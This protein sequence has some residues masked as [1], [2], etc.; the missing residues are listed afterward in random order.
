MDTDQE[1]DEPSRKLLSKA[2]LMIA[3]LGA[4][5]GGLAFVVRSLKNVELTLLLVLKRDDKAEKKY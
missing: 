1:T 4:L 3:I 2:V 5:L